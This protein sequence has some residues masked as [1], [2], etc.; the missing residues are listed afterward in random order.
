MFSP[1]NPATLSRWP[2]VD[3]DKE[4]NLFLPIL[5]FCL[6]YNI[7]FSPIKENIFSK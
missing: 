7:L 2:H 5:Q 3:D 4:K 6:K 1:R